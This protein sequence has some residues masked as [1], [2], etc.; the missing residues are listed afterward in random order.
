MGIKTRDMPLGSVRLEGFVHV[1]LLS[2]AKLILSKKLTVLQ[3]KCQ[4]FWI[5]ECHRNRV[6]RTRCNNQESTVPCL[7]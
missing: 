5:D 6:S 4:E 3:S 1:R 2:Y 7:N